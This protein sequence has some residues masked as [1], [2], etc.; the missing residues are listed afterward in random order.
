MPALPPP[1]T[2]PAPVDLG[3]ERSFGFER[4]VFFSDA[5]FA[6]AIT[7][8]A[9][10]IQ[11]PDALFNTSPITFGALMGALVP[12]L[13]AYVLSFLVIGIYWTYHHRV[14]RYIRAYDR[15]LIWL[16]LYLLMV[17][18]FI[19]VPTGLLGQ[20]G[21]EEGPVVLYAATQ[22]LTGLLA[23]LLWRHAVVARLIV[24]GLSPTIVRRTQI[25]ALGIPLIFLL[26]I[27]IAF[28]AP[29]V[30]SF[31][32]LLSAVVGFL[33]NRFLPVGDDTDRPPS[34]EG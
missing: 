24:P 12:H 9:L 6:I 20:H 26:S 18:A 5:V 19:P 31:L 23:G 15:R 27:P 8:L 11:L 2:G 17:V 30:A 10:E 4:L 16:N 22:T 3:P 7:L 14:F 33:S 28:V 21:G 32:W 29:D 25:R 34:A 1:P 13:F